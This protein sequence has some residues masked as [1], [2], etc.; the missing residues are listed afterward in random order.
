MTSAF[1]FKYDAL[2]NR[3]KIHISFQNVCLEESLKSDNMLARLSVICQICSDY[4]RYEAAQARP[5]FLMCVGTKEV[6]TGRWRGGGRKREK[7]RQEI[8]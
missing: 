5:M 8:L 7:G 4:C 2:T 3:E 6:S 1:L